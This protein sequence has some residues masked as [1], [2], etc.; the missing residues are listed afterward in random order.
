MAGAAGVIVHSVTPVESK[1]SDAD[2]IG[3]TPDCSKVIP[4]QVSSSSEICRPQYGIEC[5]VECPSQDGFDLV[6]PRRLERTACCLERPT[7]DVEG[8]LKVECRFQLP[9][10]SRRAASRLTSRLS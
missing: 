1:C 3:R 5:S 6:L 9:F 2:F 7:V 8:K 10:D 4:D